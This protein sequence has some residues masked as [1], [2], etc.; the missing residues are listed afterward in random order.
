MYK[1]AMKEYIVFFYHPMFGS[2]AN[3]IRAT[4][5]DQAKEQVLSAEPGATNLTVRLAT[6]VHNG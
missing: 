2:W 1:N 4:D 6:E 3:A 5:A